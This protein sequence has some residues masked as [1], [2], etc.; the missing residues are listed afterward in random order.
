MVGRDRRLARPALIDDV[1]Q[2]VG[3][4]DAE[5]VLPA[6]VEPVLE[7]VRGVLFEHV[8]VEFALAGEA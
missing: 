3:H 8:D 7:L 4:V 1:R 5:G 6:V 2:L